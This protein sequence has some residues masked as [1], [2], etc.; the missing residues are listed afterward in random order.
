MN[1]RMR[2]RRQPFRRLLQVRRMAR[3]AAAMEPAFERLMTNAPWDTLTEVDESLMDAMVRVSSVMPGRGDAAVRP[4]SP[5]WLAVYER[6][7]WQDR[8]ALIDAHLNRS[9]RP[10]VWVFRAGVIEWCEK[11]EVTPPRRWRRPQWPL[12]QTM[13]DSLGGTLLH[14]ALRRGWVVVGQLLAWG[15]DPNRCDAAGRTV[16]QVTVEAHPVFGNR[17]PHLIDPLLAHGARWDVR[18][19]QGATPLDVT[20]KH[21]SWDSALA[22]IRG[23]ACVEGWLPELNALWAFARQLGDE[24]GAAAVGALVGQQYHQAMPPAPPT[25][26]QRRTLRM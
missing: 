19:A 8:V 26:E 3:L 24:E 14:A 12:N 6:L 9:G 20:L 18:D 23:G 13:P 1:Q 10:E 16:L 2:L 15:A 17:Y 11:H 25:P 7:G 22:L 21:N 4:P 5:R